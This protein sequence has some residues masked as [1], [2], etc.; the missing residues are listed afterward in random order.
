MAKKTTGKKPFGKSPKKGNFFTGG[1]ARVGRPGQYNNVTA[2]E[3]KDL[4]VEGSN[5]GMKVKGKGKKTKKTWN[6]SKSSRAAHSKNIQNTN[7]AARRLR[8][9]DAP[10]MKVQEKSYTQS[11]PPR[12]NVPK[13]PNITTPGGNL[14]S[15]NVPK[16]SGRSG[17]QK[18]YT[19]P[20]G[21]YGNLYKNAKK[22]NFFTKP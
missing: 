17:T 10:E 9:Y 3:D 15:T 19:P 1:N 16:P 7:R 5:L 6:P 13:L 4:K 22:T 12:P 2:P 18:S 20:T 21:G 8:N 14:S 11:L